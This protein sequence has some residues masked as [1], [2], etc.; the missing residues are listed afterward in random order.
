MLMDMDRRVGAPEVVRGDHI[1]D[2]SVSDTLPEDYPSAWEVDAVLADGGTVHIRPIRSDDAGA[3]RAFFARQSKQSVYNRFFEP[4]K[5]LTEHEVARFTTVDFHDRMA[6]V[7]FL[8]EE[9]IAVGRY[10]RIAGAD[11]AEVAFAVADEHQGRG[12]AT[13]LLDS[14]ATY[15]AGEGILRFAA[16]TLIDNRRMLG[17]FRAAGFRRDGG[18]IDCGVAHLSFDVEP[19]RFVRDQL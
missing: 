19:T 18:P 12:L 9:M 8:G 5:E 16:D 7:A 3:H 14:L 11:E 1:A 10:D 15:A 2:R 4:R 13:L 17:V 6:F